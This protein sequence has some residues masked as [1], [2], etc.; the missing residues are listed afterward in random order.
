MSSQTVASVIVLVGLQLLVLRASQHAVPS[1][2][3]TT[4]SLFD[5]RADVS[6][7]AVLFRLSVPIIAG[8]VAAL[9]APEDEFLVGAISGGL[10]WFLV[11]WPIIWNPRIVSHG[12]HLPFVAVLTVFWI[13]YATLPLAGAALVN[14]VSDVISGD[15]AGWQA[16]YV[17][18]VITGIPIA[19][20]ARVTS[21]FAARRMSFVGDPSMASE[22]P[23][24]KL[25]DED[26]D[27]WELAEFLEDPPVL[28]LIGAVTGIVLIALIRLAGGRRR[29]NGK[30][31]CMRIMG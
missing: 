7:G 25:T 14:I 19:G 13:A 27:D 20:L 18:A 28:A 2:Y 3:F 31:R 30:R 11:I 1:L 21:S 29:G 16:E 6:G 5:R 12:F 17:W 10:C 23:S 9:L 22:S 26:L 4:S 24:E 15:A 8:A